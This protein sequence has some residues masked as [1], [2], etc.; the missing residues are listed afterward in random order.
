[1]IPWGLVV[2]L[3]AQ[4]QR[5]QEG[6]VGILAV[7][8]KVAA[9]VVT[10]EDLQRLGNPHVCFSSGGED[11]STG[12]LAEKLHS[13]TTVGV[14]HHGVLI[15]FVLGP[16]EDE[17][18]ERARH[19]AADHLRD[20]GADHFHHFG[21]EGAV[22]ELFLQLC[23]DKEALPSERVVCKQKETERH[24]K[25]RWP[26][27]TPSRDPPPRQLLLPAA[28]PSSPLA[29][30]SRE[31]LMPASTASEELGYEAELTPGT[32]LLMLLRRFLKSS[33]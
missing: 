15:G 3:L 9:L 32:D 27:R 21:L 14:L 2:L 7:H 8:C 33:S 17:E 28:S 13:G 16:V 18:G 6:Q 12:L 22:T 31:F 30:F 26:S 11:A 10:G 1:M 5:G 24:H 20:A 4:G 23:Y 29:G 25:P 19:L